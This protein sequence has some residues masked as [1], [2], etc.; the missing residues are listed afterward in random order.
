MMTFDHLNPSALF[1][2]KLQNDGSLTKLKAS[3]PQP[4]LLDEVTLNEVLKVSKSDQALAPQCNFLI[5][6][7]LCKS[8]WGKN[9]AEV[10]SD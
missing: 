9:I 1:H 10:N 4:S 8:L 3:D 7:N 2:P 6:G 5:E